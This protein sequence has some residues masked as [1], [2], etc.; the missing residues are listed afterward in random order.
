MYGMTSEQTHQVSF[1]WHRGTDFLFS[2]AVGTVKD[3]SFLIDM[4]PAYLLPND[5]RT[6][7]EWVLAGFSLGGH[8]TWLGL[9]QGA[10]LPRPV[11]P[12]THPPTHPPSPL[13]EL[14]LAP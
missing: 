8:A 2:Y 10:H 6:I 3:I 4:L 11:Y 5:E 14:P 7:G 1:L 9:R 13:T 12:P